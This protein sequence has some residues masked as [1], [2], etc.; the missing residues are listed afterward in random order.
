MLIGIGFLVLFVLIAPRALRWLFD[1]ARKTETHEMVYSVAIILALASAWLSHTAGLHYSI[2]AFIAGLILGEE[3]RRDRLLFDSLMDFGFGFFITLFFALLY[4]LFFGT[5]ALTGNP[6]YRAGILFALSFVE[7]MDWNWL[8]V[9]LP[10]VN[11]FFGIEKWQYALILSALSLLLYLAPRKE[12]K[13]FRY[14]PLLLL[15]GALNF[16]TPGFIEPP[17]KIKLYAPT[18]LQ[19][20]KWLPQNSKA[21]TLDNLD[22]VKRAIREK[23]DLV[24]LPESAFPLFLNK[25]PQ[26]EAI[27][28]KYSYQIDIITGALY[29]EN[30]LHYNVS[31]H[32]SDGKME[33]AKKLVLVPFGEY[34]PLPEFLR[35]WVNKT[36]FDGA[37]DFVTAKE[38]TDFIVKGVKFR[39]AICY[40]ATC[41]EIYEGNPKYLVAIS[42]NGWFHPSIEPTLQKLLMRFYAKKHH[43]IIFHSANM[44]GAGVIRGNR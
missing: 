15:I 7:V 26:I 14:A 17:L 21:I 5:L 19:E 29:V 37:S 25:A 34:I 20:E 32:F 10:F 41:D 3:I 13:R 38:P 11:T 4:T 12:L 30:G 28:R 24:V 22:A 18:L 36:F 40:E 1:L 33:M 8:Q 9:E 6:L 16:S 43:S 44:G 35:S 23:Y 2:G 39:N 31:Y 42:N 27:L